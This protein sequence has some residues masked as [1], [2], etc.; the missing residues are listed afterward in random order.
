VQTR[1]VTT[2]KD[3][4]GGLA[5][6]QKVKEKN[7]QTPILTGVP[8]SPGV[9][10]GPVKILKS[11]K[12]IKKIQ[13][14]DILVAKMTSPDYV[15]AMKLAGAV[16]TNEGGLTSHAA[17]V[18]R[19]LGIPC[20]VGTKEATQTLNGGLVVT[21]DGE[22]GEVYAGTKTIKKIS[23]ELSPSLL[24]LKTATKIYVNLAE[25]ERAAEIARLPFDGIGLLR[26]EFMIADIGLH[27]KEAIK[28]KKHQDFIAKLSHGLE[29]FCRNFSPRPVVYRAT[30]FKTNE[31]R[32]LKGGQYWEPVEANPLMGFRGA[33]RYLTNPDV[34][35]LEM[36]ALRQVRQKYPNLHLMIPFVRSP[37]EL[38]RVKSLVAG[39]GLFADPKFKFWLM[40]ELPV[41]VILIDEFLEIGVDGVS[42]GTNDLTMLTEGTDRDN[43]E[44]ATVFNERSP[45]L[46]WSIKRVIKACEKEG[47]TVSVCGQAPSEYPDFAET[48]VKLG[49]TSLSVNPDAFGAVKNA[50]IEAERRLG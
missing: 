28:L 19:E 15:P 12:E 10:S 7:T 30:D 2:L 44:M 26:A 43:A 46:I 41:N 14:G 39:F 13:K 34:F 33:Y 6:G 17:I 32:T 49:V 35:G 27:P 11:P 5:R 38:K 42:L 16:V 47:V 3:I 50:V 25:P 40:V 22:I 29:T 48:L 45:A 31:Y 20:V 24:K 9:A 36:E 4:K 1:P 18:S 21:V 8:A 23:A 37:A